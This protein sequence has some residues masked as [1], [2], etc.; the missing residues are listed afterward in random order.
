MLT[1]ANVLEGHVLEFWDAWRQDAHRSAFAPRRW[2]A[3]TAAAVDGQRGSNV[4]AERGLLAGRWEQ[5]CEW[6]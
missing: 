5:G 6:R 4:S 3:S 2:H 1:E